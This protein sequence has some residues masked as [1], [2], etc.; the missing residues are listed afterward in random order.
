MKKSIFILIAFFCTQHISS[1][2]I[3]PLT[4]TVQRNEMYSSLTV[5]YL[6]EVTKEYIT[7]KNYIK[8]YGRDAFEFLEEKAKRE[9]IK[10]L[11]IEPLVYSEVIE[12]ENA[13]ADDLYIRAREWFTIAYNNAD[14]VIQM[15]ENN[16]VIGKAKHIIRGYSFSGN[17]EYDYNIK[18][19][20]RDG[21]YKYTISDI[22]LRTKQSALN[23]YLTTS[24]VFVKD[25]KRRP[26]YDS[27]WLKVKEEFN[28]Y[29]N[30][31]VASLIKFMTTVADS[32][33]SDW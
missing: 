29:Q 1:Q 7:K 5:T 27:S 4:K 8:K 21:R 20:C 12:V 9:E 17:T 10:S 3:L 26:M 18:I 6:D 22:D 13:S 32:T 2:D 19:E 23:G 33:E 15:S 24:E 14:V 11:N 31:L 30:E 28:N 16:I 25:G